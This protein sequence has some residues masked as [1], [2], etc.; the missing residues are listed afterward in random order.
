MRSVIVKEGPAAA[1]AAT[2]IGGGS[3]ECNNILLQEDTCHR[4]YRNRSIL[5]V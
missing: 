4:Q 2:S 5:R 1:N 3:L